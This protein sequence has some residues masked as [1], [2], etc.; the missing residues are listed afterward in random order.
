M[1]H[2]EFTRVARYYDTLMK[3]IEYREW[4]DYAVKLFEHFGHK[5]ERILDM[6]CGTGSATLELARRGYEV[7]A[8]DSSSQM[9]ETFRQ[10]H[11]SH[12]IRIMKSDMRKFKLARP[13]D[14][15]TCFF[16]SV[17]YLTEEH[18]LVR[19]FE[20]VYNALDHSGLFVFDM[21][22]IYG[23]EKV[24]GTNTLIRE[25]DNIYSVWKSIYD[26]SRHTSTL[27][28]TMFVKNGKS[29]ERVQEVHQ[30]RAYPMTQI[31]TLLGEAGFSRT[32]I[33]AHMTTSGFLDISSRVMIAAEKSATVKT[34]VE[35]STVDR[36]AEEL[37]RTK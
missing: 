20:S 18:D 13:V 1:L 15:V 23:L 11:G 24:W 5:P 8:L 14:A 21:N 29:Y 6:A 16:D 34:T 30:E 3:N 17:N 2:N 28:L 32:E 26:A 12:R 22:T 27:Y 19:C 9:L 10:K 37:R 31:Q 4:V 33:F 36:S 25:I 7:T 35:R